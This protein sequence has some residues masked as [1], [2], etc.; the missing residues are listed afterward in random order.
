MAR[1]PNLSPSKIST[2]L[3][4]PVKYRWT[5]VDSRGRWYVRAK[6]HYSFGLTLH[7]VL[8]RFHDSSDA[9]VKTVEEVAAAYEEGWID[10]GFQS[11]E[12]MAESFGEGLEILERHVQRTQAQ[13]KAQTLAVERT[14]KYDMGEFVLMG[15]V[16][17]LDE[18][19]DGTLEIVDYKTGREGVT[20]EDVETDLAMSIYQ[21][22]VAREFPGRPVMATLESLRGDHRASAS[23]SH[24]QLD[25]LEVDLRK[26]GSAI[27][28]E[29]LFDRV[30][31]AKDLCLR[32][33]FL[34]LCR[35]DPEF[36]SV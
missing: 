22:L 6:S 11:S 34:V 17:R 26:L 31:V 32:C 2:Y 20:S 35:Q 14:L 4:C 16:D 5:Y 24:E 36:Q 33:D 7:K 8:E 3:A 15:R 29:D 18:H 10:A 9:G 25:E 1:K 21:L 27:L 13:V 30:P 19:E 12:E 23:L 28:S